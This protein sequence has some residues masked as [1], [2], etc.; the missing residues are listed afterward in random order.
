MVELYSAY[1]NPE[2]FEGRMFTT[3]VIYYS[4]VYANFYIFGLVFISLI[5][6]F[7][8]FIFRHVIRKIQENEFKFWQ[9]AALFSTSMILSFTR[10]G[11]L[12]SI[13]F[14]LL[15]SIPFALPLFLFSDKFSIRNKSFTTINIGLAK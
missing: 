12:E 7:L 6:Y 8:E 14:N 5:M 11:G 10:G 15:V 4:E 1:V 9:Y 2:M 13:T 3:P